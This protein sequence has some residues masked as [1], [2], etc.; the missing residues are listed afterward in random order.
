MIRPVRAS[1]GIAKA[2]QMDPFFLDHILFFHRPGHFQGVIGGVFEID[3]PAA[4]HA[5]EMMMGGEVG[6][7][8]PGIAGAFDDF[9]QPDLMER[10][11]GA[12]DRVQG[13]VVVIFPDFF[14]NAG[15]GG[16]F[17]RRNQ[18]F[19]NRSP[20]GRDA[21][22]VLPAGVFKMVQCVFVFIRHG[23]HNYKPI[24][25]VWSIDSAAAL[26]SSANI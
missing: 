19:E 9:R 11:K 21:Q 15:S 5:P 2:F 24:R 3:D 6:V 4:G 25:S 17:G 18:F 22:A 14:E 16:V 1:A 12:A 13:D 7:E 20:L 23:N 8:P 10:Q 26:F